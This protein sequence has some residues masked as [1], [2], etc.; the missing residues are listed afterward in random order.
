M[1]FNKST[2]VLLL[3][4]STSLTQAKRAITFEDILK[5]K[6]LTSYHITDNGSW[7]T[8]RLDVQRGNNTYIIQSLESDK[9]FEIERGNHSQYS[10]DTKWF[11]VKTEIDVIKQLN[12]EK[13]KDEKP[14][15]EI[16]NTL[17]DYRKNIDDV[18]NF[19]LAKNGKWLAYT[20]DY[21]KKE[22]LFGKKLILRHLQSETEIPIENVIE[23]TLDSLGNNIFYSTILDKGLNGLFFRNLNEEFIPETEIET[24]SNAKY[25]NIYWDETSAKLFY[26]KGSL[27]KEDKTKDNSVNI[28]N[29]N[30]KSIN[31]IADTSSRSG[32]YIP[33]KNDLKLTDDDKRLWFGYKPLT[34]WYGDDKD[35]T[36]ITESNLYDTE[37]ILDD[38]QLYLWHPKDPEIIPYQRTNWD[39][40]K[41]D[42]YL[43]Y[44]D[45]E[46][47]SLLYLSDSN[48]AGVYF[49]DNPNFAFQ[50]DYEPY[51]KLM[52]YDGLYYDL[53][54][55]NLHN[56]KK[57]L[58]ANKLEE[59]SYLSP[60]GQFSIYFKEKKWYSYDNI[61]NEVITLNDK[62]SV[63]FYDVLDD[64]PKEP[65]SYGV[66]GWIGQDKK[67]LIGDQFDV[68]EFDL[69]NGSSGLLTK[70]IGRKNENT[71]NII[72]TDK[73]KRWFESS[74]KVIV[75]V[76]GTKSKQKHLGILDLITGDIDIRTYGDFLFNY[77]AKSDDS[78]KIIIT[79]EG[80]NT[81]P[82]LWLTD[83]KLSKLERLTKEQQQVDEFLWGTSHL[84]DFVTEFGDTLQGYYALPDNYKKGKKYPVFVYFYER[85]SDRKNE[86][87]MPKINHRPPYSLYLGSEY[88]MFFPD[89]KFYDGNPG[90]SAEAALIAGCDKLVEMGIADPEKIV[91]HGHSWSGYESAWIVTQTDYFAACVSGAPVSNMTSA[92]SGIRLGSGLAR[93]FQ[94]EKQQS[95]IGGNIIDSLDSYIRNSPIF[96]ADKMNTPLLVMFGDIDEAVP[97]Q[98]GIELYLAMRRFDK[99]CIFLQYEGE[100]HHPK[101]IHNQLDYSLRMKQF[102]DYYVFGGEMPKWMLDGFRYKGKYNIG[103]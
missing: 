21:D 16:V 94:Y 44:Y 92:Y 26:L 99:N 17:T 9:I 29:Y 45:I 31:T 46:K 85:F 53:Y 91:M 100:P 88:V 90:K 2:I 40:I 33:E 27:F 60:N 83:T 49:Y 22:K 15:I 93:Q 3:L 77:E 75:S 86:F 20:K 89:V 39:R 38:T 23:Y 18:S 50:Y 62:L 7:I 58:V 48:E 74:D 1:K 103:R 13:Y 11:V 47:E 59:K 19:K 54:S 69:S 32:Y 81:Y 8:Y 41:D 55:I 25:T 102:M 24:D 12:P 67:V 66:K 36:E 84:V 82:D 80:F 79:K 95:R 6:N 68:W 63:P 64:H 30:S 65:G 56:G 52:T 37:L 57:K 61:T 101:K 71:I 14:G 10:Q 78:D 4:F 98:Q 35:T 43:S 42:V 70:G 76:Y 34:Q 51:K 96:F 97:W 87:N 28:F 72:N 5:F 73:N